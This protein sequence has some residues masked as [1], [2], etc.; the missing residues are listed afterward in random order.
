MV[1]I[2]SM[3]FHTVVVRTSA[4]KFNLAAASCSQHV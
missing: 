1:V 4:A 3:F 2:E